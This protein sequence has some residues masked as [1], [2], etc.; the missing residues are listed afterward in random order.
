M[1]WLIMAGARPPARWRRILENNQRW[2]LLAR[3]AVEFSWDFSG[4]LHIGWGGGWGGKEGKDN[5]GVH[6]EILSAGPGG[7]ARGGASSSTR[8]SNNFD[9]YSFEFYYRLANDWWFIQWFI[10]E[11]GWIYFVDFPVG[12]LRAFI[13][14]WLFY[15]QIK[16]WWLKSAFY[17]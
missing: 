9:F 11:S 17:C 14:K 1:N 15:G 10:H 13:Y 4:Y 6:V 12:V 8:A 7:G 16:H 5:S 2:I 3:R